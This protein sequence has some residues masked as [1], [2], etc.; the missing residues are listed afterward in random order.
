M[1]LHFNLRALVVW[2]SMIRAQSLAAL[3]HVHVAL[4]RAVAALFLVLFLFH[5]P[6]RARDHDLFRVHVDLARAIQRQTHLEI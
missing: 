3:V 4:F 5:V 2:S 6:V 1:M